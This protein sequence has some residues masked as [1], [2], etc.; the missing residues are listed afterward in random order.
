[1]LISRKHNFIFIHIYKNAGTSIASALQPFAQGQLQQVVNRGLK[2]FNIPSP[3]FDPQPFY[4][5]IKASELIDVLGQETFNSFFSFA[6][7]RNP[8]DWQVSLYKYM[9]KET[10]HHQHELVK[11]L[12]NFEAYIQWRCENEVKYQKDFIYSEKNEL[13]IDFVGKYENLDTDFNKI[14][15]QIGVSAYLPKLNISNTQPYQ[16]FYTNKTK[17]LVRR[18][19]EPDIKLFEYDF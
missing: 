15:S 19:F 1:M 18:T 17:E 13:L 2:K 11:K 12:G 7:V 5:H 3:F 8:W 9:L 16:Q 10:S 6:F 14:C 4:S